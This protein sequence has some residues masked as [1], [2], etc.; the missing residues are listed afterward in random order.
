MTKSP[1]TK[2]PTLLDPGHDDVWMT[3]RMTMAHRF[4]VEWHT[5][6]ASRVAGRAGS[7][8]PPGRGRRILRPAV[9]R[10]AVNAAMH[11]RR[12]GR[13]YS[14]TAMSLAVLDR[15]AAMPKHRLVRSR[16][17]RPAGDMWGALRGSRVGRR[18]RG[19]GSG[20]PLRGPG[21][22]GTAPHTQPGLDSIARSASATCLPSSRAVR[23]SRRYPRAAWAPA[24]PP[25]QT[26]GDPTAG[27]G[28]CAPS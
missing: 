15:D 25:E 2:R 23:R 12:P 9:C 22:L 11:Q 3:I 27:Q 6:P 7:R 18:R 19:V 28:G 26:A 5:D 8:G 4:D 16:I 14:A 13:R 21:P 1:Q 17:R 20:G 10:Q 24:L